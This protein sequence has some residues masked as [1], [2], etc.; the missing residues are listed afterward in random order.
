MKNAYICECSKQNN[1]NEESGMKLDGISESRWWPL[2]L[3][4]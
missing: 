2:V 3:F 4:T 1:G